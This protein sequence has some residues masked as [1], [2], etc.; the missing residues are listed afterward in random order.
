MTDRRN[1]TTGPNIP[2]KRRGPSDPT[3]RR[4][5]RRRLATWFAKNAREMPW[6]R[7][8]DPYCIWIS[9]IMLQQTQ[10]A[11]VIPYYERFL[12]ELPD[13][14]ALARA[15]EDRVLRLWEGLG[16]Y[17]RARQMHRAAKQIVREHGGQFPRNKRDVLALP[18]IGKYT[19]GAILSIALDA[20]EPILE[21]NSIRVLC[22]WSAFPDDPTAAAGQRYLWALAELML[23]RKNVGQLNQAL[24]ELGSLVCMPNKPQ[25]ENCPVTGYCQA[26]THGQCAQIPAPAAKKQYTDLREAAVVIRRNGHVLLRRCGADERWAGLWDFPRFEIEARGGAKLDRELID[27]TRHL[28]GITVDLAGPLATIKHGVTRYRITLNCRQAD[29]ARGSCNP[30]ARDAFEWVEPAEL[31]SYPLSATGRKIARL[32]VRE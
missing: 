18:G 31:E 17:R 4:N 29:Y 23:P 11:T 6:R 32:L 9:E 2:T 5:V 19:A 25:C 12:A 13:V 10:V 21:A 8:R 24:M 28:T 26:Q 22:R 30:K 15:R 7:T 14:A 1:A 27:K 16:Y 20:R 3:W